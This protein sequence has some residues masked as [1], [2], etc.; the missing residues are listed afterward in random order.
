MNSQPSSTD[1]TRKV[2]Q[3]PQRQL[4]EYQLAQAALQAAIRSEDLAGV[5]AARIWIARLQVQER[6]A[7]LLLLEHVVDK[8]GRKPS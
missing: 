7:R 5:N 8:A 4:T 2:L 6:Q 1:E 3:S